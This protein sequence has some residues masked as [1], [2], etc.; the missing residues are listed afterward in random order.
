MKKLVALLLAGVVSAPFA[1]SAVTAYAPPVGGMSFNIAGGSV[2]GPVTTSF[3]IPLL[4]APQASGMTRGRIASLTATTVTVTG[5]GWTP[6]ALANVAFPYALR[7]TSGSAAGYTFSI[8]ANTTD[9][10][11]ISGGNPTQLG[12]VTGGSGDSFRLIPVDTLNSLFGSNTFLGGDSPASA[13]TV[14]L[15]NTSQLSYYY[16]TTLSRWVRTTGPTTDR[17]NTAI[18]LDTVISVVRKS[19]AFVLRFAGAIPMERF[20]LL[21]P[22]AGSKYTHTGFPMDVTLGA[23]SMQTALQG[24]VSAPLAAN[25]DT[26]SVVSGASLLTYFHNG[27]NWQ[28]TTGPATNRDAVVIPAGTAIMLFKRGAASG[29]ALLLRNRPY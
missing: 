9:T 3:S 21:V 7:M 20:N 13:D 19:G 17:G 6:S 27:T 23:L 25:A 11:T 16:N 14:I 29:S 15:S 22:N 12:I 2:A 10:L 4:D 1:F 28:R 5:A 18:P 8:T 24:W 26:L